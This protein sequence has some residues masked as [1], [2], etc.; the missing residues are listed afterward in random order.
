[1]IQITIE[2]DPN[3]PPCGL[4]FDDNKTKGPDITTL[5]SKDDEVKF[6][7]KNNSGI[8]AIDGIIDNSNV[9]LFSTLPTAANN[10]K[11]TIGDFPPN[12]EESYTV[13]VTISDGTCSQDPKLKMR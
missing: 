6:K 11:G 3:N 5:V 8:S 9:Q 12:T 1:M 7:A 13:S 10:W 2:K 4:L